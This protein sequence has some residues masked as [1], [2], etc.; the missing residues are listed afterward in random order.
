MLK[1]IEWKEIKNKTPNFP[2][3]I[4]IKEN[5]IKKNIID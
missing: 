3:V 4:N 2:D 1:Y 5:M